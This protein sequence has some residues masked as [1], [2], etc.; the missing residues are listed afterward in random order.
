MSSNVILSVKHLFVTYIETD[1]TFIKDLSFEIYENEIFALLGESGSGKSLT[2]SCITKLRSDVQIQGEVIFNNENILLYNKK[3]ME[4]L[5]KNQI[6][7]IFQESS[8]SLDPAF[9][10][11][12]HLRE[13]TESKNNALN[14]LARVGFS[15]PKK[16]Y[17]SYPH[18]LSGGM[19]QRVMIAMALSSNPKLL[20]A[21]EPTASLDVILQK[22]VLDLIKELQRE[23]KLSILLI[24]H[25][26]A[27]VS[28]YA[29]R[30]AILNHGVCVES[31]TVQNVL[32]TP[33]NSYTKKLIESILTI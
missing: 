31:G 9:T 1:V 17:K 28:Q 19:Q 12:Y 22:Q 14:W 2:A 23:L 21:D 11:G 15:E 5:R 3:Q 6:S 8:I 33:N 29:Q 16:I 4:F 20:I 26:L 7:Y 30:T 25:D 18:E 32:S 13:C 27:L 10:I 24:T